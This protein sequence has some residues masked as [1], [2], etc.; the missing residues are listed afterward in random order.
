MTIGKATGDI[1]SAF[2][3]KSDKK[4]RVAD[5]LRQNPIGSYDQW[6]NVGKR[7]YQ[8]TRKEFL[9]VWEELQERGAIGIVEGSTAYEKM[10]SKMED[11]IRARLLDEM[12]SPAP[13]PPVTTSFA[14]QDEKDLAD[15]TPAAPAQNPLS[16]PNQPTT[17]KDTPMAKPEL[18]IK[19]LSPEQRTKLDTIW[20]ATPEIEYDDL[21]KKLETF[22]IARMTYYSA[23]N[24]IRNGRYSF[25][26]V[27]EKKPSGGAAHALNVANQKHTAP[28][29]ATN[30][31]ATE[32]PKL[33]NYYKLAPGQTEVV[34]RLDYEGYTD[35]D[36]RMIQQKLPSLLAQIFD[37]R[38]TF[39][40][41][42]VTEDDGNGNE[43]KQLELRRLS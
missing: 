10:K 32:K 41:F 37:S 26:G 33:F 4:Q 42:R 13:K 30:G 20:M 15:F 2:V 39:K 5:Y 1:N 28:P 22:T 21:M 17:E 35:E 19:A 7:A 34:K 40:I 38:A 25:A 9:E 43:V 29:S 14:L 24:A 12:T 3:F 27:Q 31:H 8:V 6:L 11:E 23:R 18:K 16:Y 36:I